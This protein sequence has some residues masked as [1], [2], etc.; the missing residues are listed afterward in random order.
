MSFKIN[1]TRVNHQEYSNR[2]SIRLKG[3]LRKNKV[4]GLI[5]INGNSNSSHPEVITN[6]PN[7]TSVK[8]KATHFFPIA[9]LQKGLTGIAVYYLI[10]TKKINFADC[11]IKL[12]T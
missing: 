12:N 5:L 7:F 9:S 8:I 2:K 10:K 1:D 6:T 3:I 11:K 4:N